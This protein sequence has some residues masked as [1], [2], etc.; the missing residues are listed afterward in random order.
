MSYPLPIILTDAAKARI[1]KL[2]AA[3]D[4]AAGVVLRIAQGKG[5]GGNEY[6]MEHMLTEQPGFD[7]IPVSDTAALYIPVTDSFM[8]F[9]MTIDFGKDGVGNEQFLFSNPNEGQR[10]GCGESFSLK[11]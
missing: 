3:K 5:C 6:K 8:M 4:G 10:C 1:E 2:T 11:N 7:K 9:G